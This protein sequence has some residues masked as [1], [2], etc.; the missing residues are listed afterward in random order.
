[1]FYFDDKTNGSQSVTQTFGFYPTTLLSVLCLP[2][3]SEIID[4]GTEK[5][6]YNA[7]INMANISENDF[8]TMIN[9]AIE[10]GKKAT[11]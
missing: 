3:N 9:K 2:V 5:H 8:Q 6:E 11:I 1:M 4:D 10:I 7:K